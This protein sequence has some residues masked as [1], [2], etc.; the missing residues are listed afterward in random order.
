MGKL[1]EML[2]EEHESWDFDKGVT[3]VHS[4]GEVVTREQFE[5][6]KAGQCVARLMDALIPEL[7]K[8]TGIHVRYFY[9]PTE[10]NQ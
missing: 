10:Q 4:G 5:A 6:A 7:A 3:E 1:L 9:P 2:I 8:C